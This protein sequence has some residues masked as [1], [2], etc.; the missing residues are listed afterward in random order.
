MGSNPWRSFRLE[1]ER[2][3]GGASGLLDDR[4]ILGGERCIR[5]VRN[6]PVKRSVQHERRLELVAAGRLVGPKEASLHEELAER[7][8][9]GGQAPLVVPLMVVEGQEAP[10]E[11][12]IPRCRGAVVDVSPPLRGAHLTFPRVLAF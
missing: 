6:L 11:L 5:V 3:P 12:H 1:P 2:Q 7:P 10:D 4:G 8:V 9:R